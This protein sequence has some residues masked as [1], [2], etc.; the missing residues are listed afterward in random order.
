MAKGRTPREKGTNPRARGTNPRAQGTNPRGGKH[1]PNPKYNQIRA[2]LRKGEL[3]PGVKSGIVLQ[4]D[5][6]G[7][8]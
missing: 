6:G 8:E 3:G 5:S 2:R 4:D 7:E 1:V